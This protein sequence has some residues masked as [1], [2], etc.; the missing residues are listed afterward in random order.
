[1]AGKRTAT[2]GTT[3]RKALQAGAAVAVG[4]GPAGCADSTT[5]GVTA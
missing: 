5:E 1:M 2:D 4:G 3:R